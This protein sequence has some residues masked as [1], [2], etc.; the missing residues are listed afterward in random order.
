MSE[1]EGAEGRVCVADDD[2][3]GLVDGLRKGDAA[4]C[5]ALCEQF[6]RRIHR[7]AAAWLS[8]DGQLA[9]DVMVQTLADA[10]RN[11][12]HFNA[13]KAT[14]AAWLHGIARRQVRLELRKQRRL[15]AVPPAAQVPI[16]SVAGVPDGRDMAED[17]VERMNAQGQ[18]AD[19]AQV[20]SQIEFEVLILTCVDQLSA[21]EIGRVVGRSERAIH[22]LLHRARQKARGRL[23]S[24]ER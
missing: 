5:A 3:A 18:V 16:D 6:G 24:D 13:K 1:V 22:S 2:H 17:A 9:E 15:K 23:M 7:L 12:A 19:V 11:I 20:L 14:F 10:A 8:G 21:R 4:A